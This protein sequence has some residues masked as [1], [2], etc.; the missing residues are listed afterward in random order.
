M[1]K[2]VKAII[3]GFC[4]SI[5]APATIVLAD[6][7]IPDSAPTIVSIKIW[8][9]LLS[10][11]DTLILIYANIPYASTPAYPVNS[12]FMWNLVDSTDNIVGSNLEFPYHDSGYGY[13]VASLYFDNTTAPTW[14]G[15]YTLELVGIPPAFTTVTPSWSFLIPSDSWITPTETA[16]DQANA[17]QLDLAAQVI[18]LS[19]Q[20]DSRW[21]NTADTSL[22]LVSDTGTFLSLIGQYFWNGAMPGAQGLAPT[23]YRTIFSAINTTVRTWSDNYTTALSSQ[24]SSDNSTVWISDAQQAGADFFNLGWDLLSAIMVLAVGFGLVVANLYLTGDAW[25]GLMDVSVWLIIA[26]RL[27]LYGLGFLGLITALCLIYIS[28]KIWGIRG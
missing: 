19:G 2:W 27:G 16:T 6:I 24:W 3:I 7:P 23:V 17:A 22:L 21:P 15:N 14:S 12:A 4:L 9:S 25:N 20:L 28:Y 10:S 18:Y 26:G 11:N 13:N 1:K 8:N 5:I